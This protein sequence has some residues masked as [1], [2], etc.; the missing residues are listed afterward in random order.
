MFNNSYN[1]NNN[2]NNDNNAHDEQW[3]LLS[4]LDSTSTIASVIETTTIAQPSLYQN[5]RR[6]L[7]SG[8]LLVLGVI[9]NSLALLILARKKTAKNSKYTLMLR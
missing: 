5:P 1:N 2:A 8:I 9:G 7:V 6:F 4:G 3:R